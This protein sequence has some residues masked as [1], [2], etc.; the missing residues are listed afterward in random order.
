M[1]SKGIDK[2]LIIDTAARLANTD[3]FENLSIKLIAQE[4]EIKAPSLYN[5]VGGLDSIKYELMIY[6]W[7]ELE[8]EMLKA[9]AGVSGYEALREM[10]RTF[11]QYATLNKGIFEA[12]LWYNKYANETSMKTTDNLFIILHKIMNSLHISDDNTDHLVRTFR[13]FLEG[14]VLLVNREAFG[15]PICLEDSF[16]LSLDVLF[17]GI[18]T[19]E[20]K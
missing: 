17:A 8:Q 11:Y 18:K 10:C 6:G 9:V 14:F 3:G 12:M 16:E 13:S 7:K 5:H 15:N 2:Q 1:N 19:L 4:L 20:E